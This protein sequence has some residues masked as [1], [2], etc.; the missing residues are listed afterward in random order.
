MDRRSFLKFTGATL[1]ASQLPDLGRA[2]AATKKVPVN[3]H[4][5]SWNDYLLTNNGYVRPGCYIAPLRQPES[6]RHG[7]A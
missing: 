4:G 1:L 7:T 5:E 3:P 2:S 6:W